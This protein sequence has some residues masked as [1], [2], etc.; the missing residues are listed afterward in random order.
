M[1][2][3]SSG[4]WAYTCLIFVANLM[5]VMLFVAFLDNFTDYYDDAHA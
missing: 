1:L 2:C 5:I 3:V 4:D